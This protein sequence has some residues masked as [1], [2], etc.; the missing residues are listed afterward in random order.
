MKKNN[1][2]DNICY[3]CTKSDPSIKIFTQTK[4]VLNGVLKFNDDKKMDY[5]LLCKSCRNIARKAMESNPPVSP[6]H[7]INNLKE[8]YSLSSDNFFNCQISNVT[9]V[10]NHKSPRH[11]TLD[12]DVQTKNKNDYLKRK[13]L[14]VAQL[15]NDMKS[16]LT[17][18]EFKELI[19]TLNKN[20]NSPMPTKPTLEIFENLSCWNRDNTPNLNKK[21]SI[22]NKNQQLRNENIMLKEELQTL[23]NEHMNLIN[24]N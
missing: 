21:N 10:V 15:V 16:D 24:K 1:K 6:I 17:L 8:S 22:K 13:S 5:L 3:V 11:I 4:K 18:K 14:V 20:F 9:L 23:K 7:W 2:V 12:H 19:A